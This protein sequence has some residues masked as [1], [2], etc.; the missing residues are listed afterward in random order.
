MSIETEM[1]FDGGRKTLEQQPS[2]IAANSVDSGVMPLFYLNGSFPH[3]DSDEDSVDD[4]ARSSIRRKSKFIMFVHFRCDFLF[5]SLLLL[6]AL[7]FYCAADRSIRMSAI[8][9]RPRQLTRKSIHAYRIT[10]SLAFF[11]C[12]IVRSWCLWSSPSE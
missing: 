10:R 11:S 9:E 8:R 4:G 2:I 6:C 12:S 1:D 5:F 7:K 3:I